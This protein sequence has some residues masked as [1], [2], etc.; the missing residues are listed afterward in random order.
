MIYLKNKK[1][2]N[3]KFLILIIKQRK[4]M[5]KNEREIW[6]QEGNHYNCIGNY[7][8]SFVNSCRSK[9]FNFDRLYMIK[10]KD[11]IA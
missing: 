4:E 3:R 10:I 9:Y 8:Y 11:K 1:G 2:N 5:W 7:N 6:R